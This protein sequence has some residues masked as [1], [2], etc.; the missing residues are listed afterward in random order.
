[1]SRKWK[2]LI[3]IVAALLVGAGVLIYLARSYANKI[4]PYI[5]DQAIS[6]LQERFDANAQIGSLNIHLPPFS[7]VEL[8]LKKG[9]GTIAAVSATDIALKMRNRPA[10]SPPLFKMKSMRFEVDLGMVASGAKSL[11]VVYLDG[12]EIHIPPKGERPK[13]SGDKKPEEK[14]E[15]KKE[16]D[17]KGGV[18]IG[19]VL[20]TNARLV[21]LPRDKT[22]KPLEFELYRVRLMD[23]GANSPMKYEAQLRNAKPPG[24]IN[25]NGTFGPWA[26]GEPGDTHLDGKYIF[27]HANL[28]VFK[29]IGGIL[30]STGEFKGSLSEIDAKGQANVP[31][32][33]LKAVGNRM[34]LVT[35]FEALVDGTNGNTILKPVHAR[36]G[37]TEFKTGGGVVKHDGDDRKTIDLDADMPAG[38]LEDVLKL[39]MKGNEPLMAGIL[40]LKAKIKIPPLS[41]K[42]V[43]KLQLDG[44]FSITD[45]KFLK[46]TIQ[47]RID[48]MSRQAQGQPKNEGIDEVIHAMKGSFLMA[49]ETITFRSLQFAI[50]GAHLSLAGDFNLDNEQLD[51]KG[52]LRVQAKLSQTQTGWKKWALKPVDPFFAKNGAGIYTKVKITGTRK[53]PKFGRGD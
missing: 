10:D 23:A 32:F 19:E 47:D 15:E 37:R 1:M 6:Y 29:A 33:Y 35:R 12:M 50:P 13:L 2:W 18:T 4:E 45:G 3:G 44:T 27:E 28:G 53:D 5:R 30:N 36:L 42:V 22:R 46:T 51:F 43:E 39:A 20:I 48:K 16:E 25:A 21:I 8:Y 34:P 24:D 52:D 14:P 17:S 40:N 49:D 11:T 26:T 7:P 9:K 31:D 38:H 41:G